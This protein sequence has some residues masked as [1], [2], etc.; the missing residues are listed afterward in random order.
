MRI[1]IDARSLQNNSQ[2]RGIGT[3]TRSLV[4][5][6]LDTDQENE[7]VIFLFRNSPVPE[8]LSSRASERVKLVQFDF[9]RRHLYWTVQQAA[10]PFLAMREKLDVYHSTEFIV[11]VLARCAKVI[12]VYD[13]IYKD[14]A[15]YWQAR[16]LLE[17]GYFNLR[18][19]TYRFARRIATLSEYTRARITDIAGVPGDRIKVILPAVDN[20]FTPLGDTNERSAIRKRYGIEKEFFLYAGA[21]DYHKNIDGILE[22][23]GSMRR[24]D[25]ALVLAGVENCYPEY[26]DLLLNMIERLGLRKRVHILGHIPK[27]DLI[28]LYSSAL[29]CV[30]LSW[31]EGFGL[32]P[33]EAMACGT[34]VIVSRAA[35]LPEVV[36]ECGLLVEPGDSDGAV[37]A[38][39]T[40]AADQLLRERLGKLG[41]LRAAQFSWRRAAKETLELYRE[42]CG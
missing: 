2:Y 26:L 9:Y 24:K 31:V 5:H 42:A 34:P 27:R 7:Y 11:P 32:T 16:P 38:M 14:F 35:S 25:V 23:F 30:S 29:A 3:Y 21:I 33:L 41:L 28:G 36:G 19:T 18:D 1:G 39:E 8:F 10:L 22:A 12:T 13:F 15:R 6:L 40:L 17:K 37:H 4:Q 20:D